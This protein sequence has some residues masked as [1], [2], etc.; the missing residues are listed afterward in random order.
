MLG[1]DVHAPNWRSIIL[2]QGTSFLMNIRQ[3]NRD[4]CEIA[5]KQKFELFHE[6]EDASRLIVLI[7]RLVARPCHVSKDGYYLFLDQS[8]NLLTI[9]AEELVC[10]DSHWP[11]FQVEEKCQRLVAT[12]L[13]RAYVKIFPYRGLFAELSCN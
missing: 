11:F 5:L 3:S 7:H 8:H 4:A 6:I 13:A 1:L 12:D 2:R 9:T 10:L